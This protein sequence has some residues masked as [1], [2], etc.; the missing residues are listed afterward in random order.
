MA[1]G[2]AFVDGD[3]G[4][5]LGCSP[6]GSVIPGGGFIGPCCWA[7]TVE[8]RDG[9]IKAANAM[10]AA[11]LWFFVPR[12]DRMPAIAAPFLFRLR[13]LCALCGEKRSRL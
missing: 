10:I 3:A 5:G 2:G 6:G 11:R 7:E 12:L 9:A 8:N 1:G 4:A 13:V